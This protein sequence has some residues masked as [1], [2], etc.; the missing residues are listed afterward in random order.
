MCDGHTIV[1]DESQR[2][3]L[4]LAI[5]HLAV[6]R[7]G[8]EKALS[9]VARKMDTP[10]SFKRRQ[11]EALRNP[12][13]MVVASGQPVMFTRFK[14]LHVMQLT[15]KLETEKLEKAAEGYVGYHEHV[16]GSGHTEGIFMDGFKA[17]WEALAQKLSS[18]AYEHEQDSSNP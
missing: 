15:L 4:L 12:K 11:Q 1:L 16:C 7:P 9:E 5:A 2:Q 14:T 18:T 13:Q 3:M 10:E 6:E 17:G 8:W